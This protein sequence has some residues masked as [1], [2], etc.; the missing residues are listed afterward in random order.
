LPE[1]GQDYG[2][3][4]AERLR[5]AVEAAEIADKGCAIRITVS[6]GVADVC[7]TDGSATDV[8]HRVDQALYGAK[9]GGRN[10]VVVD[11]APGAVSLP[12]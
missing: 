5:L 6:I 7:A 2:R 1:T 8:I 4:A 3:V 12:P 9:R 10:R 11:E